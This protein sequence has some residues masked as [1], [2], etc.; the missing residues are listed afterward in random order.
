MFELQLGERKLE[1]KVGGLAEQASGCC[2]IRYGDTSILCTAQMGRNNPGMG[3]FPLTCD[4]E[5]RFYAAGKILG[6]RFM[7]REGRPSTEAVL[8]SR[9]IDRAVRPLFPKELTN[10]IQVIATCLSWDAENDPSTLGLLGASL[11]L[12]MSEIPWAGPV[13]VVRIANIEG[14]F[15]LNPTYEEREKSNL[16]L[17]LA[18]IER[19]DEILINM[20]ESGAKE[21]SESLVMGA[22]DFAVPFLEDI[23]KFQ[24]KV[25]QE[26]AKPK[27]VIAKVELEPSV[28]EKIK[29][30]LKDKLETAL[31]ETE[32]QKRKIALGELEDQMLVD[33]ATEIGETN[34]ELAKDFLEEETEKVFKENI[35][36]NEKRPD[37]RA[38][39][40]IRPLSCEI[41]ILPRA[42]G[43]SIFSRGK[44]KILSI[45]TLGSHGDQLLMDNM[46]VSGKKRFL[47]H[48]NFPPYSVGEVKRMGSPGRREIGH[49][50]LAEK[51]L[52]PLIPG[53]EE[54]PY[55][56]R[57][58]SEAISSNGSTSMASVC[59]STLSLMQAGVP[60]KAPV[61]GISVGLVMG[62]SPK[63]Y[64]LL[65]D[66]Q[67]PED[68]YGEMDFK[69][70]GTSN[71]ITAIQMDVKTD[72]ITREIFQKALEKAKIAREQILTVI[73]EAIPEPNK[74]LSPYAPKVKI[75]QINPEKI[76]MVIGTGGKVINE[77]IDTCCVAI[78]IEDDGSVFV[79]GQSEEAMEK[80]IAWVKE[81]THEFE[82]GETFEGKVK[83]IFNFG[84]MVEISPKQDGLVHI[85]ELAPFRVNSVEDVV[86]IGDVIPVKII[87]IDEQG[88][89]DLSAKQA[90]FLP[91][92]KSAG[93]TAEK[94]PFTKPFNRNKG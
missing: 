86:K 25:L 27:A 77:I 22:Y 36:K 68:H 84:A 59:A 90:G 44:T 91:K 28:V 4:Y 81:I 73:K 32:Q 2:L 20:I 21:A 61:A 89:V 78:D 17:V 52:L 79:T 85:S 76:G 71:G 54:F 12:G 39:D 49:G 60:I 23:L 82:I 19:N 35:I 72:G 64:K 33:L 40:E 16:D 43:S 3:F 58:V 24:K 87:K 51:A 92:N 34:I 93:K 45:L 57:L 41:D 31:Y 5:E 53:F 75:I 88:R 67:G 62:K 70:A 66:I 65:T 74:S 18:G 15:I 11:V 55:T 10:E 94:K 13:A 42:H 69:V 9:L 83:R 14:K 26:I 56:I 47:H 29:H 6:S 80:A 48:Y 38:L 46:E 7:R 37:G 1:V 8:N 50:M 63:E 30:Y